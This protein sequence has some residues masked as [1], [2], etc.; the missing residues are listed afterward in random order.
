MAIPTPSE[1]LAANNFYT[2]I[3]GWRD[4]V[5]G[6]TNPKVIETS[7][8]YPIYMEGHAAGRLAKQAVYQE[9]QAKY[10]FEPNFL[11]SADV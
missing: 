2:Y 10:G 11:R 3:R 8:L 1:I 9:A 5:A 4:G 6:K 7:S